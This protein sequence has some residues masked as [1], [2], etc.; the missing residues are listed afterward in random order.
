MTAVSQPSRKN[1]HERFTL[2]VF[3]SSKTTTMPHMYAILPLKSIRQKNSHSNE[4][5]SYTHTNTHTHTH[6]HT[7]TYIRQVN[8][9]ENLHIAAFDFHLILITDRKKK[10][11]L[12]SYSEYYSSI[13]SS[14][15][16]FDYSAISSITCY[17]WIDVSVFMP[18]ATTPSSTVCKYGP[19]S[20]THLTLPT[21]D[22]V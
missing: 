5:F 12:W 4:S 8:L 15:N 9:A 13:R 18:L 6:T 10:R 1:Q 16:H 7:H 2:S 20:Y 19:V 17:E 11:A 14:Y 3:L 21:S 22:G